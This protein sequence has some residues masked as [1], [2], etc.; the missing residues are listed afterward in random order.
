MPGGA[1][2][3]AEGSGKAQG[4]WQVGERMSETRE[5]WARKPT[6]PT[7]QMLLPRVYGSTPTL[8]GAPLAERAEDLRGA[9]VAFLGV[10][11]RAPTPDSR[12]GGAAANY[13]GTLLTPGQ[14]RANSIKYGGYLPELDLDVFEHFTLVDRGDVD[15]VR[16]M[17]RTLA[18]VEAEVAAIVDAGGIPVTMGGNSGP[19]TYPVLEAIA[20]RAGGPVAVLNLDAHHDNQRGEWEEDD[21]RQPRWGSTWARRILALP[22]VDP[23]RYYH[24]GL[25]GPRNDR[26]LFARF[27]ERGV[28]RE[29]ISTYRELKAAR[30][31]GY[32]EWAAALAGRIAD[33][34][35]KVWIAVDP[36]VLNL[37]ANPDFGDEPLGPTADEVIEL[38]YQVG[39]AA[40]RQR[41][42]GLAFSATPYNAQTLHY[43][44]LYILL[45][46]LAGVVS[47]HLPPDS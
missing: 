17:G 16:D 42:G 8:F 7:V 45:Y 22:G 25:R 3:R 18:N 9:D 15:V 28:R 21:P 23:A 26:D 38:C 31:A 11:W 43:I 35:A 10:P 32:D 36:D 30:R 40:G 41:L 27:A 12:M 29:Q 46:T 5:Q 13:E 4:D 47:H 24:V 6:D 1:V 20:A 14:F 39:K 37:G 2:V 33:G 44:L 19:S 34:A